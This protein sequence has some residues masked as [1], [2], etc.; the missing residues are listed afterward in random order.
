MDFPLSAFTDLP[1]IQFPEDACIN[2]QTWHYQDEYGF[3]TMERSIYNSR[4]ANLTDFHL[5]IESGNCN[6]P[7]MDRFRSDLG[8]FSSGMGV[9]DLK[10][11]D[12]HVHSPE[13]S[14]RQYSPDGTENSSTACDTFSACHSDDLN[15]FSHGHRGSLGSSPDLH[16][17]YFSQ[18][19]Y[20]SYSANSPCIPLGGG[21]SISLSQI[22]QFED[23]DDGY[24]HTHG[25][26]DA[27]G[28][29]DNEHDHII[30]R[31]PRVKPN[32]HSEDEGLG[33]SIQ[34]SESVEYRSR[35]EI[36]DDEDAD[37]EY[38]PYSASSPRASRSRRPSGVRHSHGRKLS[39]ASNIGRVSKSKTKKTLNPSAAR[40]F[41]CPLTGYGCHSTFT[42]KNEWKRHVSTQHI[43]LGYWRCDMC[44]PSAD[45]NNPV[46]ND[47]NRKDLFTQH[48]R[49][50]HT[51]HPYSIAAS[52]NG[53]NTTSAS[54]VSNDTLSEEAVLAHQ[55]RCYR[56]LR[57]PPARSNCLFCPRSFGGDGSW[58]E[59][60]E[61]V[62]GHFERE[63]KS[64]NKLSSADSWKPD[65]LLQE[66]L[67]QE[68]L[69]EHDAHAGW[70]IGD[71]RPLRS[72]H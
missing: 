57:N 6:L 38:K 69:I 22:Q 15:Q 64:G 37:P 63:R 25:D 14:Y 26:I 27:D 59:R 12:L 34:D 71:G 10:V 20:S 46:Y 41:P 39:N 29:S 28:D 33:E 54:K 11:K 65:Q 52:Q 5:Q 61:H 9:A 40:P 7:P 8:P 4:D 36:E 44:S 42:S 47:F 1:D 17:G 24:E 53:T 62:G 48:L 68:G 58:E 13:V 35:S 19:Q 60:M 72:F 70:H 66:Y 51:Q 55:Q 56:Q 67:V 30:C 16:Q 50:M 21:S 3:N 18:S 31:P 23:V 45:P 32:I 43:K 2:N 49:R